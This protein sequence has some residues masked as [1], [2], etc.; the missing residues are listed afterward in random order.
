MKKERVQLFNYVVL[1]LIMFNLDF[2][3]N[4]NG[5]Q[6]VESDSSQIN[7]WIET[8]ETMKDNPDSAL[9]YYFK[10]YHLADS[11]QLQRKAALSAKNIGT[12]YFYESA[13]DSALAYWKKSHDL[14]LAIDDK[15][16]VSATIGNLGIVY[17]YQGNYPKAFKH[18]KT[19]LN[20]CKE[21][22]DTAGIARNLGH[23]GILYEYQGD[24]ENAL[25]YYQQ[26]LR[27]NE[28]AGN[29]DN[30]ASILTNIGIVYK[31]MN[32]FDKALDHHQQALAINQEINDRRG[33]AINYVNMGIIH[34]IKED[35]PQALE[36]FQLAMRL[37]K[38]TGDQYI[39]IGIYQN[40]GKVYEYRKEYDRALESYRKAQT[41]SKEL[42]NKE[43][44]VNSLINISSVYKKTGK[45]NEAI[46]HARKARDL[47]IEMGNIHLESTSC[48][49]LSDAY[50]EKKDFKNSLKYLEEWITLNDSIFRL[51]KTEAV[52]RLEI[53]YE[54]EK[55]DRKIEDLEKDNEIQKLQLSE[56]ETRNKAQRRL[57][58]SIALV[59]LSGILIIWF[60]YNNYRKQQTIHQQKLK[61]QKLVSEQKLLRTQMN[62]HFIYNSLNS[63]Q[64][65]ISSNQSYEAE[66]YLARFAKLMRGIL[67][68]SRADL[69]SLYKEIEVLTLYL[70]LE[71]LRFENRFSY[72]INIDDDLEKDFISIPPM[73][74]QPFIENAIL[75]GFKNTKQGKLNINLYERN[76]FLICE[77]DDNGVGRTST[78]KETNRKH[79]SFATEITKERLDMISEEYKKPTYFNIEDKKDSI[80]EEPLGTQVTIQIPIIEN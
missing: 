48:Q 79:T 65:F 1:I 33:V 51:E 77:I 43:G 52:A 14:Y 18:Y 8:A 21:I 23:I 25:T 12:S 71:Q 38:E 80:T 44:L 20:I 36:K 6:A 40:M 61:F 19:A 67:E 42:A 2:V 15:K 72:S 66:K 53:R 68:N 74:L 39:L 59:L 34:M 57:F 22:A 56:K 17:E 76:D 5:Q 16:G 11:L 35:Y 28:K 58:I 60:A 32:E 7:L 55:K 49:N 26:A 47:S 24:Y 4:V 41:I 29:L 3:H 27:I 30:T 50:K 75:H 73:L 31:Q 10:A 37:N 54:T 46:S 45:F 62:P 13:L 78:S 9:Y 63:I 70:N 69:I 64:S